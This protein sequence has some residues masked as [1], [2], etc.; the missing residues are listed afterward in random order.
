MG[1][2]KISSMHHALTL[3]RL[4]VKDEPAFL[5]ALANL[6]SLPLF[7]FAQ[8]YRRVMTFSEYL[9]LLSD[10]EKGIR[11]PEAFVPYTML[12]G[13]VDREIIGGLILRHK[14]NDFLLNYGG[15]IGYGVLPKNRGHGY[16]RRMMKLALPHVKAREIQELLITCD[17]DN[18]N[19]IKT[20]ETFA[21]DLENKVLTP[22]EK[23][24]RRYWI[25]SENLC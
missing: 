19:S 25:K 17:D 1:E 16:A 14:L 3:R 4:T 21:A 9:K 23:L 18:I 2:C 13:F 8:S 7:H 22:S 6:D 24:L 11:V 20:I 12:F 10:N 15:H 5:A